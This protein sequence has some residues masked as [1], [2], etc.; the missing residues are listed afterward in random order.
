MSEY[1]TQQIITGVGRPQPKKN[2][3][4]ERKNIR[5]YSPICDERSRLTVYRRLPTL[6]I[7]N[8]SQTPYTDVRRGCHTP[9][10]IRPAMLDRRSNRENERVFFSAT[11]VSKRVCKSASQSVRMHLTGILVRN[12]RTHIHNYTCMHIPQQHISK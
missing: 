9:K 11:C 6:P 7:P 3:L 2:L 4:L 10:H 1:T 8:V 12:Q 5:H